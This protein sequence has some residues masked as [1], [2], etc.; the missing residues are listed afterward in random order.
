MKAK[1]FENNLAL[2]GALIVLVGVSF[3]AEDALGR[4]NADITTTAVAI[5]DAAANTLAGAAKANTDAAA[6]AAES[7][8]LD[9]WIAL[10]IKLEDRTSTLVVDKK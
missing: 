9:N 5:H 7:V 6:Q 2:I 1:N 10:D 4:E 8:A 3:A